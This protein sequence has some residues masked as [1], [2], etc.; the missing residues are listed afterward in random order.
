MDS[1]LLLEAILPK[2]ESHA[3]ANL[4]E[5]GFQGASVGTT[6]RG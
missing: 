3:G 2:K 6:I 4:H 1:E 5:A